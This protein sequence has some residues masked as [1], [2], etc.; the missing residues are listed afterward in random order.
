M[1][2]LAPQFKKVNKC[3]RWIQGIVRAAVRCPVDIAILGRYRRVAVAVAIAIAPRL[4][5]VVPRCRRS[6]FAAAIVSLARGGRVVDISCDVDSGT[7]LRLLD[8]VSPDPDD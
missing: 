2:K 3:C 6:A 1:A 8:L 5:A 4:L 7:P